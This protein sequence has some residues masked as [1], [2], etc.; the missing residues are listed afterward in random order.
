M[1]CEEAYI[2]GRFFGDG[3]FEKRGIAIATKSEDEAKTLAKLIEKVYGRAPKL[4]L[5]RYK[6]GHSVWWIRLWSTE[7]AN[8]YSCILGCTNKKSILAKPPAAAFNGDSKVELCF[9][10]GVLDAEAWMYIWRGRIRISAELYNKE[11]A[12]YIKEV[13]RKHGIKCSL[14]VGKDGA[15]RL[16]ITGSHVFALIKLIPKYLP[17]TLPRRVPAVNDAG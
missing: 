9:I 14:S 12:S 8:Y 13:L 6:D 5:R 16:D 15:Y 7:V 11:M 2:L 1:K 4:K 10:I 3:W 17:A